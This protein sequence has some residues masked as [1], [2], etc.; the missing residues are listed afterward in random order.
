MTS[1]AT[2]RSVA[3]AP[4]ISCPGPDAHVARLTPCIGGS[5]H[6]QGRLKTRRFRA[7][8][9]RT[10]RSAFRRI[11]PRSHDRDGPRVRVFQDAHRGLRH[12][13][14]RR[15]SPAAVR[16]SR[17]PVACYPA[18]SGPFRPSRAFDPRWPLCPRYR[19]G[20]M[21]LFDFCNRLARHVHHVE[22][23][24]ARGGA[25]A[26]AAAARSSEKNP[27]RTARVMRCLTTPREL[28]WSSITLGTHQRAKIGHGSILRVLDRGTLGPRPRAC[29][30]VFRA[31]GELHYL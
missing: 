17:A 9:R 11:G 21:L 29:G 31:L 1:D 7:W 14:A 4:R 12:P 20:K 2:C 16:R 8:P 23:F 19:P 26:C 18:L 27:R 6:R 10:A 28:R 24:D 30:V 13:F 22:S 15:R 3:P 25:P 5:P